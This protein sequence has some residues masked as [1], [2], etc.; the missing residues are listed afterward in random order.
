[1]GRVAG[2][3]FFK[4]NGQQ[5]ETTVEGDLDVTLLKVKRET[6]KPGFYKETAQ[7]PRISGTFIFPKKFP[8]DVLERDDLVITV[9]LA[10]GDVA[11][12]QDAY[13]VDETVVKNA[14]GTVEMA[15]EGLNVL[16]H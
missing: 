1:M 11:T 14:D 13:V 6:I 4:V 2:T 8:T 7:T 3:C 10:N 15:F 9:E 16:W 12:L 5:L